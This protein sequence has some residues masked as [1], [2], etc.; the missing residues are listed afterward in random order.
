M[1][2]PAAILNITVYSILKIIDSFV[3][4]QS[5]QVNHLQTFV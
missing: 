4:A 1:S 3:K 5:T 2:N